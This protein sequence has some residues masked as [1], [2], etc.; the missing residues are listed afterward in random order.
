MA[1]KVPRRW[2]QDAPGRANDSGA[3]LATP[4]PVACRTLCSRDVPGSPT[5]APGWAPRGPHDESQ[6]AKGDPTR[7]QGG[8]K[9]GPKRE[10]S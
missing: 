5:T 6:I 8:P 4:V 3:P 2:P 1:S 10:P 9:T 7:P